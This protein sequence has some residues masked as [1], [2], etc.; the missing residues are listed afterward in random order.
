MARGQGWDLQDTGLISLTLIQ[1]LN[2]AL[3][4]DA[5]FKGL[6]ISPVVQKSSPRV[7]TVLCDVG[8]ADSSW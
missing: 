1:S 5:D 2:E 4:Q 8:Q 3:A 6:N 7:S